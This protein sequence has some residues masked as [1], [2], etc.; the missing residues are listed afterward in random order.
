MPIFNNMR[1]GSNVVMIVHNPIA[2]AQIEAN[3]PGSRSDAL[4]VQQ[5]RP[6]LHMRG[7]AAVK[8]PLPPKPKK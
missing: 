7:P 1:P 2:M 5:A 6:T 4:S 8:P 3:K